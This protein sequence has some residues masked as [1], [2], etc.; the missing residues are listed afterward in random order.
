ML[1]IRTFGLLKS[2]AL[3]WRHVLMYCGSHS[4][5]GYGLPGNACGALSVKVGG[6]ESQGSIPF[7]CGIITVCLGVN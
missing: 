6:L 2:Q 7:V 4:E 1:S 5:G 3:A